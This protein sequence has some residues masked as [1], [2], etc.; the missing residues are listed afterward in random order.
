[1]WSPTMLFLAFLQFAAIVAAQA[2]YTIY[3]VGPTLNKQVT[4]TGKRLSLEEGYAKPFVLL[5][6]FH[7]LS[8]QA[9]YVYETG[10]GLA[11]SL[12]YWSIGF[13]LLDGR[14]TYNGNDQFY[15]CPNGANH[16]SL[17][18][19]ECQD[20]EEV[21]L[22]MTKVDPLTTPHI[23]LRPHDAPVVVSPAEIENV[24]DRAYELQTVGVTTV[25]SNQV[26]DVPQR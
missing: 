13:E 7:I 8:S 15:A 6:D 26:L 17:L 18:R 2:A 9:W 25:V 3:A 14:L 23:K 20:G 1:M 5:E 10:D 12:R 21:R 11:V 24:D 22:M 4:H 19:W 16:W